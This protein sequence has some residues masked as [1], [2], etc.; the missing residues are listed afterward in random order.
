MTNAIK[1]HAESFPKTVMRDLLSVPIRDFEN[2][3]PHCF[4]GEETS[5]GSGLL[6]HLSMGDVPCLSSPTRGYL[7]HLIGTLNKALR[8]LPSLFERAY[9]LRYYLKKY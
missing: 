8:F 6:S 2:E 7:H 5:I 9:D 1:E 4:L 3:I